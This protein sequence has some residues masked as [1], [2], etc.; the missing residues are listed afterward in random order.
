[1]AAW[2]ASRM[3]Y[4]IMSLQMCALAAA[5]CSTTP[6]GPTEPRAP[7][8]DAAMDG[9]SI[10]SGTLV[11]HGGDAADSAA[12]SE[13]CD[14][15]CSRLSLSVTSNGKSVAF[16]R[17]QFALN[18]TE[19]SIYVEAHICGAPEC[20]SKDSKTPDL[21]LIVAG[22]QLPTRAQE[23]TTADGLAISL[24]DFKGNYV[25]GGN[26]ILKADTAKL[27]PRAFRAMPRADAF[28]A[29]DVAAEFPGGI[30]VRGHARAAYCA[31]LE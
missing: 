25:T 26:P 24:V 19:R 2:Y 17:V 16:D 11:D 6:S 13:L 15:D 5:A 14:T 9:A 1:M 21:T 10:E 20:P 4:A 27:T 31:S 8:N 3:R 23:L 28:V 7:I 12:L 30:V 18:G 22:V 29:F